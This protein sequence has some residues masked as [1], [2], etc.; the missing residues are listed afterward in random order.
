MTTMEL[1]DDEV[2]ILEI[3]RQMDASERSAIREFLMSVTARNQN[4]LPSEIARMRSRLPEG[5]SGRE[6]MELIRQ[7]DFSPQ[8]LTE[9]KAAMSDFEQVNLDKWDLSG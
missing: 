6:F 2:E 9:M 8:D 5:M 4:A 7:M 3:I 1:S